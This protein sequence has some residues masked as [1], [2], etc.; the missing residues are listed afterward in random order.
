MKSAIQAEQADD[1][2]AA[3]AFAVGTGHA[4]ALIP[5]YCP[6]VQSGL[7][8]L[9]SQPVDGVAHLELGAVQH[10]GVLLADQEVGQLPGFV[11]EGLLH[12][13]VEALGEGPLLGG[14]GLSDM[15]PPGAGAGE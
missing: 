1:V 4:R 5:P 15:G 13:L 6:L 14:E 7:D 10:L 8:G 2:A 9:G 11:Q 3:E 12:L